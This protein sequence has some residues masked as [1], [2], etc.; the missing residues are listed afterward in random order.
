MT[1]DVIVSGYVSLDRVIKIKDQMSIGKTAIIHNDEHLHPE[2]GGCSIN[3]AV[4]LCE[5]GI[6]TCP[7]I[8]VGYDY[9]SSGFKNY[10][11]QRGVSTKA[12]TKIDHVGTSCSY[13]IEDADTNHVTLYYPG[14]MDSIYFGGYDPKWFHQAKM[15]MMTVASHKDNEAFLAHAKRA[16]LPIYL[17]MKL[18]ED[19]FPKNFVRQLAQQV[20]G[21]FVNEG[22]YE[23]L[24]DAVH[25][26]SASEL[27]T[28][29]TRLNFIVITKGIEGSMIYYRD[30]K[31]LK[32]LSVPV[33][34][35]DAF[36]SSV[37]SGDAF[38]SGFIFGLISNESFEKCMYLGATAA[39]FA[40]EGKGATSKAPTKDKLYER[41]LKAFRK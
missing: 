20:S 1:Y 23:Y 3:F 41:C 36:V 22:E 9:E 10:L 12:I 14:A 40:I 7:I 6:K 33:L 15:A 26:V 39:T 5:L 27:F 30:F 29:N 4:D 2:Y 11:N 25:V 28:Q 24:L 37:G 38:M 17:G 21:I 34:K 35:T 31:D 18:D 19:A 13:L 8:R 16:K 32:Y